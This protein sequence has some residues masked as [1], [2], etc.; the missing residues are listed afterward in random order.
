M[1]PPV[2][3]EKSGHNKGLPAV[4][5]PTNIVP[6][7]SCSTEVAA[8]RAL[9]IRRVTHD[10]AAEGDSKR[11]FCLFSTARGETLFT[12]TWTPVLTKTRSEFYN[13]MCV[14]L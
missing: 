1:T 2:S 13:S 8:R 9:A 10:S 14:Y 12:Q 11:E 3:P 6:W 5:V 4:R 7:K